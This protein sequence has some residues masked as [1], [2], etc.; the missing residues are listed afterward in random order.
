MKKYLNNM[1]NPEGKEPV[2]EQKSDSVQSSIN[3]LGIIITIKY[4]AE[5]FQ[6]INQRNSLFELSSKRKL[7]RMRANNPILN[8]EDKQDEIY[9]IQKAVTQLGG[10]SDTLAPLHQSLVNN[11]IAN[12]KNRVKYF[13]LSLTSLIGK[14]ILLA[15]ISR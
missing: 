7:A 5:P 12:I 11:E 9:S 13:S 14:V 6:P 3:N 15:Q 4:L 1:E 10:I 2:E 8:Q